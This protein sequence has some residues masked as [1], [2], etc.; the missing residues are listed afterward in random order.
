MEQRKDRGVIPTACRYRCRRRY[1]IERGKY[2]AVLTGA[3]F[4][5]TWTAFPAYWASG[6]AP[7]RETVDRVFNGED[8]LMNF[9]LANASAGGAGGAARRDAIEFMR[10]TVGGCCGVW[11]WCAWMAVVCMG[12]GV[13]VLALWVG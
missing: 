4:L 5:D 8:L 13:S 12:D 1:S 11:W 3:A 7:A 9:V 6:V 2:N 10:P